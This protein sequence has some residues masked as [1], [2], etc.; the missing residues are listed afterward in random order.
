MSGAGVS[1]A[2]HPRARAHPWASL[3]SLSLPSLFLFQNHSHDPDDAADW[4]RAPD[5]EARTSR[6]RPTMVGEGGV[7][8]RRWKKKKRCAGRREIIIKSRG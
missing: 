8:G 5:A 7:V 4:A 1:L 2:H 6:A 3:S